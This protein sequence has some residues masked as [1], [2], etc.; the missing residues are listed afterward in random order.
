MPIN[1]TRRSDFIR[2]VLDPQTPVDTCNHGR[3]G[4]GS[5]GRSFCSSLLKPATNLPS[6]LN[7][8]ILEGSGALLIKRLLS[9]CSVQEIL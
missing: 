8:I 7:T 2:Q 5:N 3:C 6:L 9:S 4:G 1:K